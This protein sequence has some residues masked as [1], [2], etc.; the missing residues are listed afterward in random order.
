M[1]PL[2]SFLNLFRKK[3]SVSTEANKK[4]LQGYHAFEAGKKHFA[5]Q[6]DQEAV[7]CFDEADECGFEAVELFSLRGTCLQSLEWNIDA[8]D[9]FTKAISLEPQ[10][11]NLYFQRAM[12]KISIGDQQGFLIDIQ[13]AIRLAKVDNALTKIYNLQANERGSKSVATVYEQQAALHNDT[14]AFIIDKSV[15]KAKLK[16]RRK[17]NPNDHN[18]IR[19]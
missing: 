9:D 18:S 17:N 19:G 11:C 10:D 14:P 7:N 12:S 3:R 13:D 4:W 15:E 2:N 6:S 5:E 16:G 8:I 1:N